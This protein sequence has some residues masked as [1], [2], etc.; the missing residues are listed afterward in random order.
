M[1]DE[2]EYSG[3]FEPGPAA[4]SPISLSQM[5]LA[6]LD[7][8][9][10]A[11]IHAARSFLNLVLQI[12]Y[13]HRPVV[14]KQGN[15]RPD[16]GTRYNQE[17]FYDVEIDGKIQSRKVSIPSLSLVPVVPLAVE[18]ANFKLEMKVSYIYRHNQIQESEK[19][20]VQNEADTGYDNHKRPWFLVPDPISIRG[21]IGP[22]AEGKGEGG[23]ESTIQIEVNVGKVPM[24][25]GL[26]KLLTSLTQLSYISEVGEKESKQEKDNK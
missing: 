18:S 19:E 20:A 21:T 23:K 25:S 10:K 12:G 6:P 7:A 9:F 24:P 5:L 22:S 16:G 11:Q 14:D 17:F 26:D 3:K 2:K 4:M 8:I 15:T 13:P 1:A